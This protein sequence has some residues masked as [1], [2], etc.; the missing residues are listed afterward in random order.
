MYTF[1]VSSPQTLS[2]NDVP[3]GDETSSTGLT[4]SGWT[5]ARRGLMRKFSQGGSLK[6]PAAKPSLIHV[7]MLSEICRPYFIVLEAFFTKQPGKL[8]F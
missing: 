6:G 5:T 1:S 2:L 8:D 4:L 3:L 7:A